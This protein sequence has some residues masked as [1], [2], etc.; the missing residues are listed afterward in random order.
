MEIPEVVKFDG[1]EYR[2]MGGK[3]KYYLSQ[4]K[5]E[6]GRKNPKGLHVAIWEKHWKIEVPKD[7]H[8]HHVDG[9]TFNNDIE[10]LM[11]IPAME[12]YKLPKNI[13]RKK[14]AEH[15]ERVRPKA[16]EWHRSELGREWH[17]KHAKEMW[18]NPR[19]VRLKCR[20]CW[21]SFQSFKSNSYACSQSCRDRKKHL[22]K[23]GIQ[24]ESER[25]RNLLC[26]WRAGV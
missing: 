8:V 21:K 6:S 17:R 12:H 24:P 15:L 19:K 11:C 22:I 23:N 20:I 1:K 10:N 5:Q 13:D 16:S 26:K 4:S 2:R 3:R 14:M 25:G 7:F 9:N 18:V